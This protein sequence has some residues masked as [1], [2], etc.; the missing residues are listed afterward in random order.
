MLIA[1]ITD[2]HIRPGDVLMS[3][4][5]DTTPFL[6]RCVQRVNEQLPHPDV[7]LITGDLV[8][9]G[10]PEEYAR[11]RAMLRKLP[12]PYYVIP[13]N[14]DDR[15]ALRAAFLPDGYLPKTGYLQYV[16]ES[17]PLRLIALDSLLPGHT[18]GRLCEERLAWLDARLAEAPTRPTV[19]YIHHPPFDTG[20]GWL[21]VNPLEGAAAFAAVVR[22]HT[23]VERVLCGHIHRPIQ[24]RWAGTMAT[25][26]PA[27]AHQVPLDLRPG[28]ASGFA[29]EPSAYQVHLWRP[30]AGLISHTV[31]CAAYPGPFS[32][33]KAKTAAAD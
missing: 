12:C 23:Q 25:T 2:T 8:D 13:G 24:V 1:Q 14:H 33:R 30:E 9:T 29:M 21:D 7:A 6:E 32:F 27:T 3:G 10:L 18:G 31:Y 26:S 17:F 4:M 11:L 20:I 15:E 5:V 28:G 22:K 19:L 16:V